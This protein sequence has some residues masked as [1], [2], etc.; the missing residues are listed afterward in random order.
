[1][2]ACHFLKT[3]VL[4]RAH[5]QSGMKFL[6]GDAQN[7]VV[8]FFLSKDAPAAEGQ[9]REEA[10]SLPTV[11]SHLVSRTYFLTH[12]NIHSGGIQS[13]AFV[14]SGVV[15]KWTLFEARRCGSFPQKRE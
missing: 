7:V 15:W 9:D 13:R 1:M 2:S 6:I 4:S 12:S 8:H 11:H 14:G 3:P 10:K 5:N